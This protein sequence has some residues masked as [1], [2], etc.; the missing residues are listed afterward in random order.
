MKLIMMISS[1]TS[2]LLNHPMLLM[3]TLLIQ[4]TFIS[5][6]MGILYI[7][8]WFSYMMFLILIGSILILFTYMTSVASNEKFVIPYTLIMINVLLSLILIFSMKIFNNK[9]IMKSEIFSMNEKISLS[10]LFFMPMNFT[11][12]VTIIYLLYTLLVVVKMSNMKKL[13]FNK[14]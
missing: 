3:L 1:L 11:F 10:K 6:S 14:N 13:I 4:T 2:F 7:S 8:F 12:I 9:I 5:M